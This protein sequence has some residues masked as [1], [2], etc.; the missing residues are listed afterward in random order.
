MGIQG[1][2]RF[3]S[4]IVKDTINIKRISDFRGKYVLVDIANRLYQMCIGKRKSGSDFTNS[5]GESISHLDALLSFTSRL[6]SMGIC[7]VYI[8]DGASPFQKR[9]TVRKRR[10]I[11]ERALEKCEFLSDGDSDDHIKDF[12]RS[13]N[14]NRKMIDG[15]KKLLNLIGIPYFQCIGEADQD[16]SIIATHYK[17][18]IAGI[19][20]DDTD[21]LIFGGDNVSL[22]KDFSLKTGLCIDIKRSDILTFLLEKSNNI[23]LENG[24]KP[25][26]GFPKENFVNFSIL[27]GTDY[28]KSCRLS[29]IDN[30]KLFELFV[31][32][33]F[34]IELTIKS[35]QSTYPSVRIPERFLSACL[36]NKKIYTNSDSV[37]PTEL[38]LTPSH[39][40]LNS[41]LSFLCD[42]NDFAKCF[43]KSVMAELNRNV[44]TFIDFRN[45]RDRILSAVPKVRNF[46]SHSARKIGY[47][48]PESAYVKKRKCAFLSKFT[49]EY[50]EKMDACVSWRE[51][52]PVVQYRI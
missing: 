14:L 17:D 27:M 41:V 35:L 51:I 26:D 34:S 18:D 8:F 13:F 47:V 5:E 9:E 38:N 40:D 43:V 24:K 48:K 6:L 37:D 12:K 3:Y 10:E 29:K 42:E 22:L 4:Q 36:K 21:M 15:C 1:F 52:K 32:N 28:T 46:F 50:S 44:T 16:C 45:C 19:I 23:L 11:R 39:I 20:S 49:L 30:E 33:E 2:T 25:L 31:L 7:P